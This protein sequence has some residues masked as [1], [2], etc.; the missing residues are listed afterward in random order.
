[1]SNPEDRLYDVVTLGETMIRL[2]PK[3]FTRLE[4]ASELECRIGGSE[5]NVAIALARIGMRTAWLS[6][7]PLN[8]LGKLVARRLQSLGVD[9]SHVLWS[10]QARAGLYFIE[11]GAAPRPSRVLYD[12][13]NSAASTMEPEEVPW[14][15]VRE[16]RH[17]HLTGITPALSSSCRAVVA[18]AVEVAREA[19]TTVS[20]DVNY[21][22]KL[23]STRDARAALEPLMARVNLVIATDT[24]ARLIFELSGTPE[25]MAAALRERL[26]AEVVALTCGPDG[27]V[28]C[29][30]DIT[31]APSFPVTEVDRVGAGDAFD[32]GLI[33]G[34]LNGD[35]P[36]GLQFGMA[37]AAIKHSIPGDEFISS[38][39]EV[40]F[41]LQSTHREI[42]R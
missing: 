20:F 16:S 1:M 27:A 19:R 22:A 21:R 14:S 6:K 7:L 32:A 29:F 42:Q 9:V 30:G 4:E 35:I 34:Y 2:T 33:H 12:R 31:R 28:C 17:L 5:S 3:G 41:L 24:D 40:H 36:Y 18:R 11:P 37:M 23:W 39:E 38:A 15:V 25:E 10:E 8:S 13:A 26:R